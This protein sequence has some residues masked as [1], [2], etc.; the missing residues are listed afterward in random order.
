MVY[1]LLNRP[2]HA[3]AGRNQCEPNNPAGG[4]SGV[5]LERGRRFDNARAVLEDA[6]RVI[7]RGWLQHGWY[8]TDQP[9]P[10]SLLQRLRHTARTPGVDEVRRACLVAAVAVAAPGRGRPD[11]LTDAG[12]ALDLVWDALWETRGHPG[13]SAAGRAAAPAVRAARMRDLVRWNDEPGRTR[14][15]V[16]AL[17]DRAISR[18]ILSALGAPAVQRRSAGSPGR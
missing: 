7:E 14:D 8:V 12:P 4:A 16:L 1:T 2:Q 9:P 11:V 15:E 17:L 10:R 18:G 5:E 3:D 13:P 6:R